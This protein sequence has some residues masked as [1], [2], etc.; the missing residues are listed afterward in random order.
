MLG[1]NKEGGPETN[2]EERKKVAVVQGRTCVGALFPS[3][4]LDT[5]SIARLTENYCMIMGL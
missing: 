2:D 1:T 3:T 4:R 5:H